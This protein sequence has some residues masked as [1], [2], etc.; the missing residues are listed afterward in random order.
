ME[1]HSVIKSNKVLLHATI[2]KNLENIMP[3]EKSQSQKTTYCF[4]M[5]IQNVHKR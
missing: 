5:F 1:Y 4:I 3:S 2:L